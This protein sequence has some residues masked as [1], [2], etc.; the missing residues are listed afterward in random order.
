MSLLFFDGFQGLTTSSVTAAETDMAMGR[1]D[2]AQIASLR[3]EASA[4]Y[5]P[6]SPQLPFATVD[7]SNTLIKVI[8]ECNPVII[9]MRILPGQLGTLLSTY[10]FLRLSDSVGTVHGSLR[11][12]T[13]GSIQL[14][15]GDVATLLTASNPGVLQAGRWSYVECKYFV[16][17]TTGGYEIRVNGTL[18]LTGSSADTRNAGNL[19]I[20]RIQW[21]G[22]SAI[23]YGIDDIYI[24][25]TG[26]SVNN[27]FLG[28][29]IATPLQ[30]IET[31]SINQFV[32]NT[33]TNY[34]AVRDLSGEDGD[35]TFVSSSVAG[36]IDLYTLQ[37]PTFSANTIYAVGV[38][39]FTR[40]TQIG[41]Q[42]VQLLVS[43]STINSG[44]ALFVESGYQE[45][46]SIFETNPDTAAAWTLND[47]NN[48]E[49]GFK[50][51]G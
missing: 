29:V 38:S 45:K 12:T 49:I 8:P 6:P 17:D 3:T 5:N 42:N 15:R 11:V 16:N 35:T 36:A 43:S 20:G 1:Y 40:K 51:P 25:N 48:L 34:T 13:T 4:T 21:G 9:G 44:S 47:L 7:A 22:T 37:N 19:N 18:V 28:D 30:I 2:Q 10:P 14:Y 26:S 31:G 46:T 39:A 24:A 32:A 23:E 33:G 41:N 27:D 50:I